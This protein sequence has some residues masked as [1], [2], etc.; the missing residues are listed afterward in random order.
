MLHLLALVS[1]DVSE[2]RSASNIK[3][4]GKGEVGTTLSVTT[5]RRTLQRNTSYD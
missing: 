5:N 2:E 1:P 3:V 4:T